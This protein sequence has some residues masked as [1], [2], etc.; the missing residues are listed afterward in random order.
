MSAP[1]EGLDAKLIGAK[2]RE[3]AGRERRPM[4]VYSAED[5][6]DYWLR[7]AADH[8]EAL[9]AGNEVTLTREHILG[10]RRFEPGRYRIVELDGPAPE[11]EF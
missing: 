6:K 7:Q 4:G 5:V 10:L 3:I 8:I 2:L 11:P 9:E 1:T